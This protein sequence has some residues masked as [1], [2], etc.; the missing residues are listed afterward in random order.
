MYAIH[1]RQRTGSFKL[2]EVGLGILILI[3]VAY[4]GCL[5]VEQILNRPRFQANP[6]LLQELAAVPLD[7]S[8]P[9]AAPIGEWPQ[10]RGPNRDGVSLE[11]GFLTSW[12]AD[13]PTVLWKAKVGEGYSSL[14]VAG[15]RVYTLAQ[16]NEDEAII[17]WNAEDGQE[18]WRF[19]Y[20][21]RFRSRNGNGPRS[22][23]TVA[24]DCVYTVGATGMLHCRKADSGA[25]VWSNDLCEDFQARI[26]QWGLAFSPLVE[27]D[28]VFVSP[29]GPNGNSVAALDK[30]TGA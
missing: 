24:D 27:G 2:L 25:A 3:C 15:G 20:P 29:G 12:P 28:L 9:A 11:T 13:G 22:T 26:P 8:A 21:A 16:D 17:C 18:K 5:L 1:Q 10:W 4:F 7:T 19:S 30:R 14:A 6:N 23:P